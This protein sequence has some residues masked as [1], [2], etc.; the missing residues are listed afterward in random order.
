MRAFRVQMMPALAMETVCCSCGWNGRGRAAT[1]IRDDC[2]AWRPAAVSGAAV[3]AIPDRDGTADQPTMTSWSTERVESFI[4]SN[5][6][7]QQ[8]PPSLRTN[9]PLRRPRAPGKKNV[10]TKEEEEEEV[11]QCT[12]QS[13]A[14]Q[15]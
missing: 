10:P 7:M 8:I 5:S 3:A 15:L 11:G 14:G 12:P 1:Q 9:A 13:A 2:G 6:S 4:L